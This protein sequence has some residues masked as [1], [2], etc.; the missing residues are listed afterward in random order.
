MRLRQKKKKS[1]MPGARVV[2]HRNLKA[3]NRAN[4]GERPCRLQSLEAKGQCGSPLWCSHHTRVRHG[5]TWVLLL[6]LLLLFIPLHLPFWITQYHCMLK[7][8]DFCYLTRAHE[9]NFLL[10][11]KREFELMP[12]KNTVICKTLGYLYG[13]STFYIT[14]W[15]WSIGDQRI[16]IYGL[17]MNCLPQSHMMN[18]WFPGNEPILGSRRNFR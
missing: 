2:W 1:G 5:A 13:I 6:F 17:N 9:K 4:L 14:T 11:L 10:S 18:R 15:P 16:W 7:L 12:F 8:C 3:A